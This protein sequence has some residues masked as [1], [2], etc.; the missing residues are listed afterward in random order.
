MNGWFEKLPLCDKLK[1]FDW[2]QD[3]FQTIE[4]AEENAVRAWVELPDREIIDIG[5]DFGVIEEREVEIE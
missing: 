5:K 3:G 2:E 4:A 1:V